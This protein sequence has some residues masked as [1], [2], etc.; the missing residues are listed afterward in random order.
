MKY[1][2]IIFACDSQLE[3][4]Y[5]HISKRKKSALQLAGVVRANRFDF[6]QT[7]KCLIYVL[8]V[9]PKAGTWFHY[10][11]KYKYII[12]ATFITFRESYVSN[13]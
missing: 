13:F 6:K 3:P 7:K 11:H 8:F 4:N 9:W 10:E 12:H 2:F 1:L 5:L